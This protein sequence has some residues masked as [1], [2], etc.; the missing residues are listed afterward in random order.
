M[1]TCRTAAAT[2]AAARLSRARARA[3]YARA[4]PLVRLWR[5]KGLTLQ[6]IADRLNRRRTPGPPG[7]TWHVET[8]CRCLRS[9]R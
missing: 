5:K 6:A 9:G 8:V 4:L 3:R 2:K 7:G 1:K